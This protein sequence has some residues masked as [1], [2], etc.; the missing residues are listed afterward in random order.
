MA[1]YVYTYICTEVCFFFKKKNPDS[2]FKNDT[3]YHT[4]QNK[5]LPEFYWHSSWFL[6]KNS[7]IIY[8][9]IAT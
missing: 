1:V 5:I 7:C 2:F 8:I 6:G 4:S 3:N 9:H